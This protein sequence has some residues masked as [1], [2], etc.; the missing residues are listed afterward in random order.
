MKQA[1][2]GRFF[3][4]KVLPVCASIL[5][6]QDVYAGRLG[7][8]AVDAARLRARAAQEE[9]IERQ[10]EAAERRGARRLQRPHPEL[11]R[12]L[13]RPSSALHEA[14]GARPHENIFV[15]VGAR[16]TST[17]SATRRRRGRPISPSLSPCSVWHGR[18][19]PGPARRQALRKLL[20]GY[21]TEVLRIYLKQEDPAAR[22]RRISGGGNRKRS[23]SEGWVEARTL[24]RPTPDAPL[25]RP[26]AHS[27]ASF[28]AATSSP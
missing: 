22:A 10:A 3:S 9:E 18:R 27:L 25:T 7:A 6:L 8:R 19:P 11:R 4:Y 24:S 20:S 16:L 26:A 21:G 13:H 12:L 28:A 1:M 23:F 14:I 17:S 5:F 2:R 15:A